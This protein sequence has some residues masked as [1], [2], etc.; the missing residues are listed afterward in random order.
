MSSDHT[1]RLAYSKHQQDP[2]LPN[3]TKIVQHE[4]DQQMRIT[5]EM[6]MKYKR[7]CALHAHEVPYACLIWLFRC[8]RRISEIFSKPEWL[9]GIRG[10]GR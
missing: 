1:N 5:D 7:V 8:A 3:R 10:V 6:Y 4:I 9:I 2:K